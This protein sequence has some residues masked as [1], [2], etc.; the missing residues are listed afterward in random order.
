[1]FLLTLLLAAATPDSNA[2]QAT[3]E[4]SPANAVVATEADAAADPVVCKTERRP[5]S[6]FGNRVCRRQS[7]LDA[8]ARADRE[9]AGEM[10]NRPALNPPSNGS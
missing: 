9:S 5:N 1:M 10:I 3:P 4:T 7:E 8:R 6:R 2:A